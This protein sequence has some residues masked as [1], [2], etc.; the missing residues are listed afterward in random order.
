MFLEEGVQTLAKFGVV[1]HDVGLGEEAFTFRL[2]RHG[3]S[4][5]GS[6]WG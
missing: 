1:E 3:G 6:G 4:F 2:A 5:G